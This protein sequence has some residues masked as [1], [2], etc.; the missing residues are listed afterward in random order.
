MRN[1]K[2]GAYL[3]IRFVNLTSLSLYIGQ[4]YCIVHKLFY[5]LV[6]NCHNRVVA[7]M[8]VHKHGI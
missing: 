5:K 2:L 1:V 3:R 6:S 4:T 8:P 7:I